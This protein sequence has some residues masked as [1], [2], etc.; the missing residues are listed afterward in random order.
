MDR[1]YVAYVATKALTDMIVK[2][3]LRLSDLIVDKIDEVIPPEPYW[4]KNKVK[5]QLA[6]EAAYS[7]EP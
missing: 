3:W 2:G 6:Q 7:I 5:M 1:V 4:V